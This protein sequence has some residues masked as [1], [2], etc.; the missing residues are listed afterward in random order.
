M[1]IKCPV[2]NEKQ[3]GE[4]LDELELILQDHLSDAHLLAAEGAKEHT[5]HCPLCGAAVKGR[6]EEDLTIGL[7]DHF[8]EVHDLEP[9]KICISE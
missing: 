3:L 2:C 5:F 1:D 8:F 4:S 9:T 7:R 6:D